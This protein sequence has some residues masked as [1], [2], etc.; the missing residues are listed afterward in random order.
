MEGMG[1]VRPFLLWTSPIVKGRYFVLNFIK[2]EWNEFC[3]LLKSV[4]VLVVVFFVLSV[5]S[6]N[7]L[8][9][10]SIDIPVEWLALDC[11]IIVSW[12]A[13]FTMDI[14][15]KHFGPKAAPNAL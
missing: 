5:F 13:F 4:P 14:L 3:V 11:G 9:N 10:K 2:K 1:A 15:T 7:H 8:A 6:M 12:F